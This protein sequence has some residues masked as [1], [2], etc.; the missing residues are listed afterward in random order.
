MSATIQTLPM[1]PLDAHGYPTRHQQGVAVATKLLVEMTN[2]LPDLDCFINEADAD[3]LMAC[4]MS[5]YW[6]TVRP[7][8]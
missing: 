5:A 6:Q 7:K 2:E 4:V 3:W 1:V 8:P